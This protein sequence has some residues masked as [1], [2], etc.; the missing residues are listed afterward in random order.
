MM[1]KLIQCPSCNDEYLVIIRDPNWLRILCRDCGWSH[2][3]TIPPAEDELD[4]AISAVVDAWKAI[5]QGD[6]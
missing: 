4:E 2:T 6:K 3:W 5:A 1:R